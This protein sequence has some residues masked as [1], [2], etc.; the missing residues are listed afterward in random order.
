MSLQQQQSPS[1][2]CS[3][4]GHAEVSSSCF[5]L[6]ELKLVI[7]L[8][9]IQR[10][11]LS[12][13]FHMKLVQLSWSF[14]CVKWELN[15]PLK[16]YDCHLSWRCFRRRR[17]RGK[18]RETKKASEEVEET[19]EAKSSFP[20]DFNLSVGWARQFRPHSSCQSRR[21]TGCRWGRGWSLPYTHVCVGYML[22]RTWPSDRR[23]DWRTKERRMWMKPLSH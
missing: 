23:M 9:I 3:D 14:C 11:P 5:Y 15:E 8:S 4:E 18:R 22:K 17:E 12:V 19:M 21:V 10:C 1:A 6:S 16:Q 2:C 13:F 20:A 7:F